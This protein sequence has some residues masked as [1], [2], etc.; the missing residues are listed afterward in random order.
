ML[1]TY[2]TKSVIRMHDLTTVPYTHR[3][4]L[5]QIS[6][7]GDSHMRYWCYYILKHLNKLPR[8][9]REK[10]HADFHVE[11]I[12]F[13]WGNLVHKLIKKVN[14]DLK[15]LDNI[16]GKAKGKHK[17]KPLMVLNA[18]DWDISRGNITGYLGGIQR[19]T[20]LLKTLK[21]EG[22]IRIMYLPGVAF[23]ENKASTQDMKNTFIFR[24]LNK[25]VLNKM[26]S[27][28]IE[29]LDINS[30]LY[31]VQDFNVEKGHYLTVNPKLQRVKGEFGSVVADKIINKICA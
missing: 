12:T 23:A 2:S 9:L 3:H 29:T 18:I 8:R 11:S 6:F 21:K 4:C 15:V 16:V 27:I 5:F 20:E 31:S 1:E 7:I 25:I 22:K 30:M 28:G 13:R 14:V 26:S 17:R 19:L 24:A 10:L